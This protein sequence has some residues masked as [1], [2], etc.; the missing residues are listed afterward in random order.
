MCL[1]LSINHNFTSK[2]TI[3][4]KRSRLRKARGDRFKSSSKL[5]EQVGGACLSGGVAGGVCLLEGVTRGVCP[6]GGACLSGE[7]IP[8]SSCFCVCLNSVT[9]FGY[10]FLQIDKML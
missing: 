4:F 6:S 8:D 9:M 7:L 1:L 10:F 2:I 5:I 3:L